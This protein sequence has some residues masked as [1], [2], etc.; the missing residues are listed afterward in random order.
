[1]NYLIDTHAHLYLENFK[2]DIDSVVANA[3]QAGVKACLLP[4]IDSTSTQ[5]LFELCNA[6]PGFCFPMMGLHPTSVK[7]NYLQ[8]LQ[9]VENLLSIHPEIIAIGEVGID[10]Y[11]DKTF[12]KEQ[13]IVFIRQINLAKQYKLPLVIHMRDSMPVTLRLLEENWSKELT[14]VFHCFSGN[15]DDAK[16]VTGLGF[17]LGIGG[18]ATFSKSNLPEIIQNVELS[19][20]VLETDCPFLAPVPFRGKRNEPA[21][22]PFIAEKIAQ[23]K[24]IPIEEVARQTTETAK[25]TFRLGTVF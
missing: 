2:E 25:N 7:K 12:Q 22:L 16:K 21:F 1:M 6:N 14:G 9:H 24:N 13:E 10:L 17:K 20:L 18:V 4:H 11:W 3:K 19:D 5:D 23:L 8:E 15:T